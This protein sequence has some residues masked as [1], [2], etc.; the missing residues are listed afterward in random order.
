MLTRGLLL[1]LLCCSGNESILELFLRLFKLLN[2]GGTNPLFIVFI[3]IVGGDGDISLLLP[4]FRFS[5]CSARCVFRS[6]SLARASPNVCSKACKS[7]CLVLSGV[8]GGATEE[9]T[10]QQACV[11][12]LDAV[13]AASIKGKEKPNKF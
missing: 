5:R 12:K 2:D 3:F 6:V 13:V 10:T 7:D 8:D 9:A 4:Y 11:H 1:L